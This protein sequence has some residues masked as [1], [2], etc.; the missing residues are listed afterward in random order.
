MNEISSKICHKCFSPQ[1]PA[2][3]FCDS[4]GNRFVVEVG[5]GDVFSE[6]KTFMRQQVR[7][8]RP[9]FWASILVVGTLSVFG[10]AK[11]GVFDGTFSTP[12]PLAGFQSDETSSKKETASAQKAENSGDALIDSAGNV[13]DMSHQ[14]AGGTPEPKAKV[15]ERPIKTKLKTEAALTSATVA[16]TPGDDLKV[17][18]EEKPTAPKVAPTAESSAAKNY[19]RG[20]M[21]GCFYLTASGGKRYVDRTMCK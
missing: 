21:G 20:P 4:C 10:F 18:F 3:R 11:A 19:V 14:S 13:F 16:E 9:L 7:E 6:T 15:A 1:E 17:A 8:T 5:N 2:S 12:A